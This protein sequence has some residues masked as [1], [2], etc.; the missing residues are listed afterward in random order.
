MDYTTGL[1]IY[2]VLAGCVLR[3]MANAKRLSQ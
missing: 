1:V 2:L 3:F